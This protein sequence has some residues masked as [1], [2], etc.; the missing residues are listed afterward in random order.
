MNFKL[1]PMRAARSC[2]QLKLSYSPSMTIL[3]PSKAIMH[4][5]HTPLTMSSHFPKIKKVHS[6]QLSNGLQLFVQEDHRAPVV[7]SQVWYKVGSSY[8][9]VGITGISHA[10][11]HM[12]FKG[13]PKHG[14][15]EFS[16]IIAENGGDE[17][18]FTAY[19][20][21]G[22]YQLLDANKL[23][24]SFELEADRMRHLTLDPEEFSKEI[25]VVMEE[26]RTRTEDNPQGKAYERWMAAA[27]ISTAYHHMPIGWMHDLQHMTVADLRAWYQQWYAPNNALVVVVGDVDPEQVH[28]LAEQHFGHLKPAV[29]PVIK[30]Q[31]EILPLG[32]RRVE[33]KVCAQLPWLGMAYNA[34]SL[35]N[36]LSCNDPYVLKVIAAVLD[37]GRSSRLSADLVRGQEI[38]ADINAWYDPYSRLGSLFLLD[39][40]PA[41]SHTVSEL[42]TALGH[43]IKRLKNTLV[44]R[45]ELAR[46]KARAIAHRTYAQDSISR[47]A[48]EIGSLEAVGL[49][50]QLRDEYL[51]RIS[52]VTSE[53]IQETARRYL[54][55]DR[56][57]VLKLKPLSMGKREK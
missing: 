32:K 48:N 53:Q 30:P 57:T 31:L 9:P 46:V 17:N 55:S 20:Y 16:R 49:S 50:W 15:G 45:D 19:D 47:Q 52:A 3:L 5:P 18:A 41:P 43:Q 12:M 25:Q 8:E 28:Q 56:L 40:T 42:E 6:W 33:V 24:I 38:A 27:H 2:S 11:E 51:P 4:P 23:P 14:M 36:D 7:V 1:Q 21:T 13:T 10:L 34:P 26:R 35:K 29:L 39:A 54:T 37:G 22:Y 44:T